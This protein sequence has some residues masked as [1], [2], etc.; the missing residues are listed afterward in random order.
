MGKVRCRTTSSSSH[1]SSNIANL[2]LT[3]GRS[4][5]ILPYQSMSVYH[6]FENLLPL[7]ALGF[8]ALNH[9]WTYQVGYVFPPPVLVLCH[10]SGRTCDRSILT[11]NTRCNVLDG[12]SLA[13][14][15][16]H[17]IG[18]HYSPVSCLKGLGAQGYIITA[19]NPL[20]VERCVLHRKGFSFSVFQAMAGVTEAST[21]KVM[22]NFGMYGQA[23]V[24]MKVYQT[25]SH[26]SLNELIC[27]GSFRVRLPWHTNIWY[28][29]FCYF[30][31]F[32]TLLSLKGLKSSNHLSIPFM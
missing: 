23:D 22:S 19:F 28:L 7:G 31:L 3:G 13:C 30:S 1:S 29:L 12:G 11:S 24:F 26:L 25:I 4:V 10:V 5:G 14:H 9:P 21:T 15:S 17:H 18:R 8:N 6:T 2:G 32:R 27:F 16:S 20:A